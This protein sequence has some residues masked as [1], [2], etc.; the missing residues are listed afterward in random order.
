MIY[1]V[2][3]VR[4]VCWL[5]VGCFGRRGSEGL[6][7]EKGFP[8]GGFEAIGGGR[9]SRFAEQQGGQDEQPGGAGSEYVRQSDVADAEVDCGGRGGEPSEGELYERVRAVEDGKIGGAVQSPDGRRPVGGVAWG[10][11]QWGDW[12]QQAERGVE[13]QGVVGR[14]IGFHGRFGGGISWKTGSQRGVPDTCVE[15]FRL[16][17]PER[18]VCSFEHGSADEAAE[19]AEGV[20]FGG[21]ARRDGGEYGGQQVPAVPEDSRARQRE[22]EGFSELGSGPFRSRGPKSCAVSGSEHR[23]GRTDAEGVRSEFDG[24]SDGIPIICAEAAQIHSGRRGPF[25]RSVVEHR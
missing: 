21:G 25:Q 13:P 4:F 11:E 6:V 1:D 20:E 10:G 18:A 22:V 2:S 19:S 12:E 24:Q 8:I 7:G 3:N 17:G 16:P 5:M 23:R 9:I 14:I 15:W